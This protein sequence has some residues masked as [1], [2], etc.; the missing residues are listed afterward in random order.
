PHLVTLR[1]VRE[2]HARRPRPVTA[3]CVNQHVGPARLQDPEKD[4]GCL[5]GWRKIDRRDRAAAEPI[6]DEMPSHRVRSLVELAIAERYVR[7]GDCCGIPAVRRIRLDNSMD[8]HFHSA[9]ALIR[10]PWFPFWGLAPTV[11]QRPRH[12]YL[13]LKIRSASAKPLTP[14]TDNTASSC[15]TL[16]SPAPSSTTLRSALMRAVS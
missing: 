4:D 16:C 8:R 5:R 3:F 10:P 14:H 1:S 9:P 12:F 6:C 15:R 2:G 11:E 7:V 13:H